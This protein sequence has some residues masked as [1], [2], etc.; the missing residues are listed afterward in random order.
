[1]TTKAKLYI[2]MIAA[3]AGSRFGRLT[4]T[5]PVRPSQVALLSHLAV[6]LQ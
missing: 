3:L 5:N 4:A 2:A 1:M 6:L